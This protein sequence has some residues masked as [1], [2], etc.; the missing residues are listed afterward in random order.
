[1]YI[2]CALILF[3]CG[4]KEEGFEELKAMDTGGA[5]KSAVVAYWNKTGI[6][7]E[8]VRLH[9]GGCSGNLGNSPYIQTLIRSLEEG[10]SLSRANITRRAYQETHED[11]QAIYV[12]FVKRQ[13]PRAVR[14]DPTVDY[15]KLQA[16]CVNILQFNS[17]S[18]GA[19]MLDLK[20]QDLIFTGN[21]IAS[22]V[23][24]ALAVTKNRKRSYTYF[25][26]SKGVEISI[27]GLSA[28]PGWLC[29]LRAH[30]VCNGSLFLQVRSNVLQGGTKL[31]G[32]TYGR[33]LRQMDEFCEI[34]GLAEHSARKRRGRVSLL[35][36]QKRPVISLPCFFMGQS[37]RNVD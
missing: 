24:G 17:V 18:R 30:K 33:L 25:R 16:A 5:I 22:P 37:K 2:A 15:A 10:Q 9:D 7:G 13:L 29:V 32:T 36:S 31:D 14:R 34:E 35:R 3:R 23:V 19:E 27:C 1:M 20:V 8:Y 28:L 21:C 11:L 12:T 4:P 26:F 6:N